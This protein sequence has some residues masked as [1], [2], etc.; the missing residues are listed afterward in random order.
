VNKRNHQCVGVDGCVR[1][2]KR[3][4]VDALALNGVVC[5]ACARQKQGKAGEAL[6]KCSQLR[7]ASVSPCAQRER[8]G[9]A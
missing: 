4:C 9:E 5:S 8:A 6:N 7:N 1:A 2:G 3:S